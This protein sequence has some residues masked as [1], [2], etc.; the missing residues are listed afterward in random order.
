MPGAIQYGDAIDRGHPLAK[1]LVSFW[2]PL[3]GRGAGRTLFDLAGRN[4]G[5]LTN[6]PTWTT[7]PTGFGAV[8]FDGSDDYVLTGLSIDKPVTVGAWV[9]PSSLASTRTVFGGLPSGGWLQFRVETSGALRWVKSNTADIGSGTA[10]VVSAGVWTWVMGTY[11]ASGNYTFSANGV[12]AGSGTNSQT[13]SPAA[14]A[15]G[16]NSLSEMFAGGMAGM[17]AWPGRIFSAADCSA[18]YDQARR[19]F[20]DL[21]RRQTRRSV[22]FTGASPPPPPSYFL[23][24]V[25]GLGW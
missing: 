22:A 14:V 7:G 3:P 25:A 1:G 13:I 20:P 24:A 16:T 11:D 2:L 5:T 23:P 6:G 18:V 15:F 8:Q 19:G 4:D 12:A 21:L 17:C 10:G 9:N